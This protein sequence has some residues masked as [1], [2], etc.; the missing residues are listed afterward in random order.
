MEK[1]ELEM[2]KNFV[3]KTVFV[4]CS[5]LNKERQINKIFFVEEI[6]FSL[7]IMVI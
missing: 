2:F 6:G 3:D 1:I 5:Q 4:N 7:E